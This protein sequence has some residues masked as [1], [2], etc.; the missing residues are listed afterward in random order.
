MEITEQQES[1]LDVITGGYLF[2]FRG[3]G[4]EISQLMI[5]LRITYAI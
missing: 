5:V 1:S 3:H 4:F 2:V